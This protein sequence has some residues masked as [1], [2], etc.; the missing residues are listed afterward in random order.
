MFDA[1]RN[2]KRLVQIF[3]LFITV[4]FAVWGLDAYFQGGGDTTLATIGKMR[5]TTAEF[6]EAL[7]E[8]QDQERQQRPG[9]D[10]AALNTPKMRASLL[11]DMVMRQIL[12]LEAKRLH[13][14]VR[15]SM[16]EVIQSLP[17]F[18]DPKSGAFSQEQYE[19]ALA[20]VNMSVPEFEARLQENMLQQTLLGA[21]KNSA[22]ASQTVARQFAVLQTETRIVEESLA[23]WQSLMGQVD[24]T[25]AEAQQFYDAN[26]PKFTLPEQ[27]RVEY[28]VLSQKEL[29]EKNKLDEKTM[30]AWYDTHKERFF[31]PEMRRASHIL[32]SSKADAEALLADV[33]Q[34]PDR[35]AELAKSKSTDPG[36][37]KQD[38]DLGFFERA[39]M[40]KPFADAA[41]ALKIGEVSDVVESEFGFHIILLTAVQPEHYRSFAEARMEVEAELKREGATRFAENS[42]KFSTLVF[43]QFDSL[44]PAAD[45]FGLVARQSGWL[46]REANPQAGDEALRSAKLRNAMFDDE[47]LKN[48]RN[49]EAVEIAPG[50]MASAR[51]LEHRPAALLPFA[52]VRRDILTFLRQE[53]A[54]ALAVERGKENLAEL[55]KAGPDAPLK[56]LNARLKLKWSKPQPV[57]RDVSREKPGELHP[58]SIDAIFRAP[59]EQK[60]PFYIGVELPGMGYALYKINRVT[61][62]EVQE[63]AL[64]EAQELLTNMNAQMQVNAYLSALRQRYAV[65]INE[66]KLLEEG[67]KD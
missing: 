58:L 2:N 41:F 1:I 9:A 38:G 5:I 60:P 11:E 48:G 28:L 33:R 26:A 47:V 17:E 67:G 44:K 23:T 45:A 30:R 24:A 64:A 36:S 34:N 55:E 29:E 16:R 59:G 31:S 49:S 4:P 62:G 52:D 61:A 20:M 54:Q 14:D 50:V 3:L 10:V 21:V 25:E 37:A 15:A 19:S 63:G 18:Q 42:E 43:E 22:F 32:M 66:K 51:L 53:K 65:E 56:P 6:R 39:G 7:R 35:F 46:T 27:A 40:V 8:R 57:S 13:L 12:L